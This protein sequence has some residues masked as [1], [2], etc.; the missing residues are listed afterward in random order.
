M[1]REQYGE[2]PY[3]CYGVKGYNKRWSSQ[4]PFPQVHANKDTV[5]QPFLFSPGVA[6]ELM[7]PR[8]QLHFLNRSQLFFL[9]FPGLQLEKKHLFLAHSEFTVWLYLLV[10]TCTTI[11][12]ISRPYFTVQ[13]AK[14]KKFVLMEI[15]PPDWT[16]RYNQY[17]PNPIF[18]SLYC[19][20]LNFIFS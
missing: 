19:M 6:G 12:Q 17:L 18:S 16:Q 9:N 1:Y 5:K 3:W 11:G 10:S 2:Y 4:E 7:M 13:P 20:I 15:P 14:L 8:T